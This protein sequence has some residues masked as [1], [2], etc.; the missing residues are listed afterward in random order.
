MDLNSCSYP[1]LSD[2]SIIWFWSSSLLAGSTNFV[3]PLHAKVQRYSFH[4]STPFLAKRY[5]AA[6]F[7]GTHVWI[8]FNDSKFTLF[9]CRLELA[10]SSFDVCYSRNMDTKSSSHLAIGIVIRLNFKMNFPWT[11]IIF[12]VQ[13]PAIKIKFWKMKGKIDV[14]ILGLIVKF[15]CFNLI[16]CLQEL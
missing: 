5:I 16:F 9:G 15:Q 4:M 2:G 14:E 13:K 12:L 11:S 7:K 6:P 1:L 3:N 8:E 10:V